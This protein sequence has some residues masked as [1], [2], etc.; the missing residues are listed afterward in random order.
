[1]G[2]YK[3][4]L[5]ILMFC[6]VIPAGHATYVAVRNQTKSSLSVKY[7][8]YKPTWKEASVYLKKNASVVLGDPA[9]MVI[10]GVNSGLW[11]RFWRKRPVLNYMYLGKAIQDAR[12][13]AKEGRGSTIVFYPNWN[14]TELYSITEADIVKESLTPRPVVRT[15]EMKEFE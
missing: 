14:G 7:V 4:L 13:Y 12:K 2:N 9:N 11:W 6:G 15:F 5:A 1:M 3:V 8:L 10:S